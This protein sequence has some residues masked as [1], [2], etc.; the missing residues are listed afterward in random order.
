M[1]SSVDDGRFQIS[2]SGTSQ[3][4]HHQHFLALMVGAPKS[5]ALA[6]PRGPVGYLFNY[7]KN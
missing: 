4:G 1:F 7:Q 6:P 3:G 2:N 5:L